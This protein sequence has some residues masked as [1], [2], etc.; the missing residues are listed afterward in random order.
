MRVL[1]GK[2]NLATTSL[3]VVAKTLTIS[4]LSGYDF[5]ITGLATVYDTTTST[6]A[7]IQNNIVN[8]TNGIG[9]NGT[10]TTIFTFRSLPSGWANTDTLSVEIAVPIAY[11]SYLLQQYQASKV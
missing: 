8:V 11:A 4:G 10:Q 7:T 9:V 2:S 3:D 5:D 6:A 1:L